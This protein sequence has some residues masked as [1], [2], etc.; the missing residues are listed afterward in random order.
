MPVAHWQNRAATL[1]DEIDDP[2]GS[3]WERALHARRDP[4]KMQE[5]CHNEQVAVQTKAV[6][7]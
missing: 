1:C 4:K 2:L 7:E 3:V 6:A 5:L